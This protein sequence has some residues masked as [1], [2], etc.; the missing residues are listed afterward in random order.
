M[1]EV[2]SVEAYNKE[3]TILSAYVNCLQEGECYAAFAKRLGVEIPKARAI[4]RKLLK[5][6]NVMLQDFKACESAGLGEFFGLTLR[7]LPN[8]R[9]VT[10]EIR[11][12]IRDGV[13]TLEEF[14]GI[15]EIEQGDGESAEYVA[16]CVAV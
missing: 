2:W 16:D 3:K 6:F 7:V 11:A 13:Y 4:G 14:Y 12:A 5:Q 1:N 15:A 8:E 10:D 9:R